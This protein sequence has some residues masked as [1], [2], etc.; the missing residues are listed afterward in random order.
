MNLNS[1]FSAI[2]Y[3][4]LAHVD[5]P[6]G[7]NQHEINGSARLLDF[8]NHQDFGPA[9]ISWVYFTDDEEP[10]HSSSYFKFYDARKKSNLTTGRI[11]WRL[12]YRGDFLK[13]ANP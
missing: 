13:I 11:E 10:L 7:S 8:F 9:T 4:R 12:Y 5:L 2:A 1:I 6:G 3:K